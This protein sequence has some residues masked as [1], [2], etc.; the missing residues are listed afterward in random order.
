MMHNVSVHFLNKSTKF[1]PLIL[2]APGNVARITSPSRKQRPNTHE[3]EEIVQTEHK[4]IEK[5]NSCRSFAKCNQICLQVDHPKRQIHKKQQ[6]DANH[7]V[8][9]GKATLHLNL[10]I[11]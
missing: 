8:Q 4:N 5:G 6:D 1:G 9:V 10:F 11:I 3:N 2:V 7:W